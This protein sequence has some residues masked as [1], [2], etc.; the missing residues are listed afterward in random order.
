MQPRLVGC[1]RQLIGAPSNRTMDYSGTH[2]LLAK[3]QFW[4]TKYVMDPNHEMWGL[5]IT[6][7]KQTIVDSKR[8]TLGA[9]DR[10]FVD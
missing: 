8:A 9:F 4:Q 3:I 2:V 10:V 6:P 1:A 5:V 7:S